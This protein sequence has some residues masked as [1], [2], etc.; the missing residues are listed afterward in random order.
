MANG[1]RR[2]GCLQIFLDL[3]LFYA[4]LVCVALVFWN[5]E[6]FFVVLLIVVGMLATVWDR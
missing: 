4:L 2:G 5:P 3:A 1:T 6:W